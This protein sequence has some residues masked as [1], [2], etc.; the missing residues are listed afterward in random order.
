MPRSYSCLLFQV[1][2]IS[3]NLQCWVLRT[4]RAYIFGSPKGNVEGLGVD[5]RIILKWISK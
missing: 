3:E 4:D 1:E 5:G 2:G